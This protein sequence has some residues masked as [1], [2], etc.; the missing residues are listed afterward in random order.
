MQLL[1]FVYVLH[2]RLEFEIKSS[3]DY[4]HPAS[5]SSF[6]EGNKKN[7]LSLYFSKKQTQDQQRLRRCIYFAS[8]PLLHDN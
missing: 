8:C 1:V 6:G 4:I 7:Q 5:D 3:L 2:M